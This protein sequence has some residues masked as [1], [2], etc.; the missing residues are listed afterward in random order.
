MNHSLKHYTEVMSGIALGKITTLSNPLEGQGFQ[1]IRP[2][3]LALNAILY[4]ADLQDLDSIIPSQD[5][6]NRLKEKHFLQANDIVISARS[7]S[8]HVALIK[9]LPDNAKIIMNNNI[10]CLRPH[11]SVQYPEAIS[12][13]LNSAWFRK[14]VI[15]KTF[16]KML[17]INV[18]WL[19]DLSF[20]LPNELDCKS[21][22]QASL[23]HRQLKTDL[24]ALSNHSDALLEA[25]LFSTFTIEGDY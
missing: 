3:D 8:Y 19:R 25:K 4:E 16:P 11:P 10:I 13:Y 18:K 12:V 21:I 1:L 9:T 24:H 20:T 14:Q 5:V 2:Q 7:T 17:S 15:A 23:A 6:A 22:A